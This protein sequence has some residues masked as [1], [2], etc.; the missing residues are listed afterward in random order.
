[1]I[2]SVLALLSGVAHAEPEALPDDPTTTGPEATPD[3][4]DGAVDDS[5]SKF[6]APFGV[7]TE[8]VIGTA[9]KPV[10]FNWRRSTVQ[11]AATGSFLFELNN[12]NSMRVGAL[13][14]APLGGPVF[15]IGATYVGVW[16]TPS[17]RLLALTPYRQPGR[18]DRLEVDLGVAM[19]I[20]EGV[21]TSFPRFMP[22][23]Q[24]VFNGYVGFRYLIYPTGWGGMRPGQVG[25]AIFA[26]K[27]S[28]IELGNLDNERKAAMQVDTGR[29]NFM[30]GFGNDIY[31]KA[32]V[33][34]S[35]RLLVAVPLI[36][37]VSETKL[38][39]WADFSLA[40]GKAF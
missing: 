22:A 9:S 8:R 36:A 32:G 29:Y 16:D 15:E 19:P 7:L 26:P 6:R 12:F 37:P 34:V 5:I 35:P 21:V 25:A 10:L 30:A 31:S 11:V 24:L 33:F 40:I 4:Y 17:S 3:P 13:V 1:M 38:R 2:L 39:W 28:Q 18:P 27:I 14:R 23:L 20:A